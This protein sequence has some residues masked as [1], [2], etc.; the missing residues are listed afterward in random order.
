MGLDITHDCFHSSYSCF[1]AWRKKLCRAAGISFLA[2]SRNRS[3]AV[4]YGNW[5]ET[6][7]DILYVLID[8]SDCDGHI[9][10]Q[11]CAPLADRLEGLIPKLHLVRD[12]ATTLSFVTGLR[13]AAAKGD[14]VLF[15]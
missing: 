9:C 3:P 15:Q 1:D 6:P 13:T 12:Q 10:A 8:H 7:D 11:H 5:E 2:G 14:Q 4:F